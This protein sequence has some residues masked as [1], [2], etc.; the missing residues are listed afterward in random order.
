MSKVS[1]SP[2][3]VTLQ[4]KTA[5]HREFISGFPEQDC[6]IFLAT[7]YQNGENIPNYLTKYQ[8]TVKYGY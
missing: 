8:K 2:Y 1:N 5:R 7:T 4:S 6:Q 3:L